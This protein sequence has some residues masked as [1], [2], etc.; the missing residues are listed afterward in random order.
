MNEMHVSDGSYSVPLM[1]GHIWSHLC[2]HTHDVIVK[3]RPLAA[4]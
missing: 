3:S 4:Y 1:P 2:L